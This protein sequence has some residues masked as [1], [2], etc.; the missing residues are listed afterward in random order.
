MRCAG[1]RL[2]RSRPR[3]S[4]IRRPRRFRASFADCAANGTAILDIRIDSARCVASSIGSSRGGHH[5]ATLAASEVTD[6]AQLIELMVGRPLDEMFPPRSDACG[7]SV[8]SRFSGLTSQGAFVGC[9]LFSCR[10]GR[11]LGIAGLIGAGRTEIMRAIFGADPARPRQRR[12]ERP[13][14]KVRSLPTPLLR[15][16]RICP[17]TARNKASF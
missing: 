8:F 3:R 15:G 2:G 6:T 5:I 7:K 13:E 9:E 10:P 16:W 14:L 11:I 17:R 4:R 12:Q 1:D